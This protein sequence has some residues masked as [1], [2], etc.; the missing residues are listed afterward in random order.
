MS[1]MNMLSQILSLIGGLAVVVALGY[2]GWLTL[3]HGWGW[4]LAQ[5]H[6]RVASAKSKAS[7]D[8]MAVIEPR[9]KQIE[10]DISAVKAKVGL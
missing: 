4:V 10:A 2:L 7:A 8:I 5:Y 3:K 9:L 6:K 1:A